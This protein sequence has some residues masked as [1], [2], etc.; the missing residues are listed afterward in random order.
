MT[1]GQ[2]HVTE[3]KERG[4]HS[5]FETNLR[6]VKGMFDRLSFDCRYF[7]FDLHGGSGINEEAKVVG[8]PVLFRELAESIGVSFRMHV[9]EIDDGRAKILSRRLDDSD[10]SFVHHGDNR[11]LAAMIPDII[12][13]CRENPA[14]AVGSIVI[15]PNG[16]KGI[17]W[18]ELSDVLARCPRLDVVL[19]Y[20][21]VIMK[22]M[23]GQG[24]LDL[25]VS[26]DQLPSM[27]N[28]KHWWI[29]KPRGIWQFTIIV[30][31]NFAMGDHKR[32]QLY[33]WDSDEGRQCLRRAM[34]T[35]EERRLAGQKAFG[36]EDGE[37]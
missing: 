4:F 17:P 3:E 1:Q 6:A 35:T 14:K 23:A 13:H 19:N 15:D 12:S 24:M 28:K 26:L 29:R 21:A 33:N 27:L 32:I 7:H 16:A 10:F 8:S 11:E 25:H 2:S 22:R 34:H 9:A 31:R 36:L 20:N 30:G 37:V 18:G 5:I